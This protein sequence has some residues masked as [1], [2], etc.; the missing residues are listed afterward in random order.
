[1][2]Q[3]GE[4][5]HLPKCQILYSGHQDKDK[6]TQDLSLNNETYISSLK[7]SPCFII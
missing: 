2:K 7:C 5:Q 6:D 4:L 3:Y 1:M